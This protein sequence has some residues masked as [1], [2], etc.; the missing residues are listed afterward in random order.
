M[1]LLFLADGF[2]EIEALTPVDV[3][4]RAGY[5]L[6]TVAARS[7]GGKNV[8]GAH[9]ITVCADL[10][11]NEAKALCASPDMVILPG[12]MPGTKNLDADADVDR[13][14]T[15]AVK[16]G[17]FVGAI[18]AAPMI[19]GKRGIL[20]GKRAVCFPGFEDTLDG[21][22]VTGNRVEIDGNIVT[23]CG[24]GAANEFALALL[25]VMKGESAAEEMRLAI[26]AK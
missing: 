6:K 3:L 8:T 24:M 21:A 7:D 26:L 10:T 18:C 11:M 22:T 5:D 16:R 9:G 4:R 17:A 23:A 13:Y 20:R 14:V 12:G 15:D 1:I 2:E 25:S 19:L